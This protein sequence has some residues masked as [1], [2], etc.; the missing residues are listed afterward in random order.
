MRRILLAI[1][2][3]FAFCGATQ[4]QIGNS[5]AGDARV[6]AAL[7]ELGV[8]YDIDPDGDYKVVFAFEDDGRSQVAFINSTTETLQMFEIREVWSPGFVSPRGFKAKI[9]NR[10]L[11]DSFEKK[12]G[13]WQTMLNKDGQIA[14]FSVK[15]AADADPASLMAI[16]ETVMTTADE[17]EKELLG[18]DD[19]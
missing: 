12:L 7:D 13:A 18:S 4:A 17:M 16:L 15:L 5:P 8:E 11:Q 14:V 2:V 9:A 10:L 3:V 19:F 6:R 1:L